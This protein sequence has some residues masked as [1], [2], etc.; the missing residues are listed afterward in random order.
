MPLT[1]GAVF[2]TLFG[3]ANP[4]IDYWLSLIDLMKLLDLIQLARIAF[5]LVVL[6]CVWALLR[7]RLPRFLRRHSAAEAAGCRAAR[8]NRSD[9]SSRISSSA[10]PPSCA[11]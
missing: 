2:L 7:P 8:P 6:A 10:R 1:L 9:M 4:V 11:R 5:W 3:A